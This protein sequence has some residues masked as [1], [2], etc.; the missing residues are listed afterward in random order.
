[1]LEKVQTIENL[2]E[3][4][5][6]G[7]IYVD[8]EGYIQAF[9]KKAKEITG[10]I[11]ERAYSHEAG[12]IC[13]GDIVIIA[14]NELGNDDGELSP[15]DLKLLNIKEKDIK[16][17]DAVICA[18]VYKNKKIDPVIKYMR[19][20]KPNGLFTLETNY[21][22][23][24]IS[25][26]IDFGKCRITIA[27]NG[28]EYVMDY[29]E[30][31]GHMVVI[32]G[33]NGKIKFFQAKGYSV[34]GEEAR[35]LLHGKYYLEKK[36]REMDESLIPT[37]GA[38]LLDIIKESEFTDTV[39][40]LLRGEGRNVFEGIFEINK[41][42][43]SSTF[44]RTDDSEGKPKGV[45]IMI[46]DGTQLSHIVEERNAI[47]SQ[48]E[49]MQKG[50]KLYGN[51]SFPKDAFKGF[52]G[53]DPVMNEVKQLAYK[54]SKTKFNVII[55]GESG[56]GKSLLAKEIHNL[57]NKKAPFVEVNCNA[58]APTL[59]E[60]ELFGYVGGAFTGAASGGK[61]GY[62]E[63][64][65]GGTIFLDE[66]GEIPLE[67]QIK[68]LH[69]L[70]NKVIYRVGSSKPIN[71][72]VRVIA[73]TNKDLEEEVEKGSFRRDLFYRIN[74]FPINIPPLRER[75]EDLYI[76]IN[77]L[78]NKVCQRY[79]VEFKQFSGEALKKMMSYNWPGNVR[80]LENII[81]R[82]ITLC[83]SPLI[84]A[85]HIKVGSGTMK[86]TLR[87]RLAEEER[88]IISE[89]L[90]KYNG[91]KQKAMNELGISKSVMYK[92]LKDM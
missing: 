2:M 43:T 68:L 5:S 45:Y 29:F 74:V 23:F 84:Y 20:Y 34:R 53:S 27:V 12:R 56:T 19:G 81:E 13:E 6:R 32:D 48:I 77:S 73:A 59:F 91:D 3:S 50:R 86:K 28:D 90:I 4:I 64:A 51:Y 24:N 25:A 42:V 87:E 71:V 36:D 41:R 39:F 35:Q 76:L 54:A 17:G 9:S 75:K 8:A 62:F 26:A 67:I 16:V 21:L 72:N 18:G 89:A 92:K 31:I 47:I 82:A 66:I 22:G 15:E 85:E 78:L 10:I 14:D 70:Q 69:V 37:V 49:Q 58:I 44:V 63:E 52:I 7:L 65:D 1:M 55:T 79:D 30:A 61:P 33:N 60:S 40:T 38:K 88:R 46:Q 57:Q 80:E 83:D 11:F